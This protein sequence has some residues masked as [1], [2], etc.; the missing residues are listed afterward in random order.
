MKSAYDAMDE[1]PLS[2]LL[3]AALLCAGVVARAQDPSPEPAATLRG[4]TLCDEPLFCGLLA[5]EGRATRGRVQAV[6]RWRFPI[7]GACYISDFIRVISLLMARR[8][9]ESR[10]L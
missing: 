1:R 7:T 6:V 4:I 9:T 3:A 5:D 2:V 10:S 8:I